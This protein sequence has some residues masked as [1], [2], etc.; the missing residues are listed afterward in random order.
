MLNLPPLIERIKVLLAEDTDASATY[1]A[2]E[3]RLALEK[4]CYDRLRQRHDY[5]SHEQL[6]YLRRWQPGAVVTTLME[7]VDPHVADTM[8]LSIGKSPAG[9]GVKPEE[10]EYVEVGTQIGFNAKR[11]AKLWNALAR[12]ALHA[13]LPENIDEQIPDYGDR[14]QIRAKVEET[15]AELERISKGTM[16]FSGFGEE[17][18]FECESCHAKNKRRAA[19]LHGGESV[20]CINPDCKES[21]AVEKQGRDIWFSR[22][23]ATV[24]CQKCGQVERLPIREF[25]DMRYDQKAT[26]ACASCDH[27]N[28]LMWRL[29]QVVPRDAQEQT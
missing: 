21:W 7:Q 2:L 15:L 10:D 12:L 27:K 6:N 5:I 4:V 19:L 18:S 17:V 9:S 13:K 1:A 3:A 24:A 28:Y 20:F 22:Q 16:A 25:L 26:I 23:T 29:S 14:A 11:V 8:T